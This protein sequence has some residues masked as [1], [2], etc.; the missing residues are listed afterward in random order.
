ML[1]LDPAQ[2][3]WCLFGMLRQGNSR[4]SLKDMKAAFVGL[5]GEQVALAANKLPQWTKMGLSFFGSSRVSS[6][7]T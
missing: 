1:Q 2:T 7:F 6:I 3:E 5:L 4:E